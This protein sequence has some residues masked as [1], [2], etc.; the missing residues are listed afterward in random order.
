L[1][2]DVFVTKLIVTFFHNT[3]FGKALQMNISCSAVWVHFLQTLST[4]YHMMECFSYVSALM[5]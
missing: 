5:T 4:F 1:E 2:Q 3:I